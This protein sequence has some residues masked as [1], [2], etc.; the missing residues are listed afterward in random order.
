MNA[1]GSTTAMTPNIIPAMVNGVHLVIE[2]TARISRR[3]NDRWVRA[4]FLHPLLLAV[5]VIDP[6]LVKTV[7]PIIFIVAVKTSTPSV[8]STKNAV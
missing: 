3:L 6:S 8:S 4:N 2:R 7:T 5:C 1:I